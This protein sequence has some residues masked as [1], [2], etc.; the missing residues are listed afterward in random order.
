MFSF[1]AGAFLVFLAALGGLLV[2]VGGYAFLQRCWLIAF[3]E[4][5]LGTVVGLVADE[6][7]PTPDEPV[8]EMDVLPPMS[9][10]RITFTDYFGDSHEVTSDISVS[11]K[12]FRPGD[13][14]PVLYR[15]G[16][17]QTFVVN[18]FW[19]KWG[20]PMLFVGM[21]AALLICPVAFLGTVWPAFGE[22]AGYI[23]RQAAPWLAPIFVFGLPTMFV[24]WGAHMISQRLR[25]LREDDRTQGT[26]VV[27]GLETSRL[28]GSG[29]RAFVNCVTVPV[30]S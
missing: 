16:H 7:S 30:D 28:R 22:W 12:K 11:P 10:L 25:R 5:A 29:L 17:P 14:V 21:G 1:L 2:V 20:G 19:M 15:S 18:R 27:S 24:S 23:V 3:G 9:P 6:K 26:I 8:T 4:H 13:Q